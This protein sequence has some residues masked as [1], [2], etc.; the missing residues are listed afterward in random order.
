MVE[1]NLTCALCSN[2]Q[3]LEVELPGEWKHPYDA[4]DVEDALCPKHQ[5]IAPWRE[6]QCVGCVGGWGDCDLWRSFAY[7]ENKL[8]EVEI[9]LI[10]NGVCPKRTNGTMI[11]ELN[12][13]LT[14][15]DL[16]DRA[17]ERVGEAFAQ[18]ILDYARFYS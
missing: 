7:G 14:K 5:N 6:S 2:S 11:Y 12:G 8:S 9:N 10:R 17:P 1:L 4:V 3:K 16:S 13:D 15:L 18:A